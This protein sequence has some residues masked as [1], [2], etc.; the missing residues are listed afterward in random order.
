MSPMT[1]ITHAL[2]A[3]WPVVI[4]T[5]MEAPSMLAFKPL[6]QTRLSQ[7]SHAAK[8]HELREWPVWLQAAS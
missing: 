7:Q 4:F 8:W 1:D 2:V 3:Q 5:S 6:A